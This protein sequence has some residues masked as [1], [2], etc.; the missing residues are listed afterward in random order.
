MQQ[1]TNTFHAMV[2]NWFLYILPP[3]ALDV[4]LYMQYCKFVG[5]PGEV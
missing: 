4:M 1:F 5:K 2:S 3:V